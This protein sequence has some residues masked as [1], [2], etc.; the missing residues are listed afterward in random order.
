MK[1]KMQLK[2]Y[3]EDLVANQLINIMEENNCTCFCEKCKADITAI[4]LN[5]LPTKYVATEKGVC[6]AKLSLY[7]N[8]CTIDIITAI[9]NAI[10]IVKGNP[11]HNIDE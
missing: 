6:Y 8:Q 9:T 11:R 1:D 2:N 3:M 7:E 4:A 5:H 10:K